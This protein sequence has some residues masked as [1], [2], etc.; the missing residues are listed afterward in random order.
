MSLVAEK[1]TAV[2]DLT[3]IFPGFVCYG[4]HY[5]WPEGKT[6]IV[7]SVTET[8]MTVQYH[9]G[10]G[11]VTNHFIIPISDVAAQD[12][13]IRWSADLSEVFEYRIAEPEQEETGGSGTADI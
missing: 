7:T 12:W 2:F 6:G 5:T 8:Q 10:I 4:R 11:N 13:E 1:P 3:Q 9:P